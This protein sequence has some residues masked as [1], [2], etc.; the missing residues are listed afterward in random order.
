MSEG[1]WI[2][3]AG[4]AGICS[5]VAWW[6]GAVVDAALGDPDPA[7]AGADDIA[8]FMGGHAVSDS[9]RLAFAL[10]AFLVIWFSAGLYARLR[11]ARAPDV[12][13]TTTLGSGLVAAAL[14]LAGNAGW[15]AAAFPAVRR[16][17]DDADV[18][19]YALQLGPG[20]AAAVGFAG[21][22][23]GAGL[24]SIVV[25]ALPRWLGWSAVVVAIGELVGYLDPLTGPFSGT[26]LMLRMAWI[27][28]AGVVLLARP[29][30]RAFTVEQSSRA[31]V[32]PATAA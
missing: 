13:A 7:S 3:Q 19:T 15:L 27:V 2:R 20:L 17:G 10:S 23:L 25:R 12:L 5:V 14:M 9:A 21:L 32:D 18:V 31:Q 1:L 22:L 29:V 16:L 8:A 11:T 4:V 24:A 26:F 6:T 30:R 28:I